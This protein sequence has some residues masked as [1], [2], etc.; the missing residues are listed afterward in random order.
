MAVN[1]KKLKANA[2]NASMN[3]KS[4]NDFTISTQPLKGKVDE[5]PRRSTAVNSMATFYNAEPLRSNALL[6]GNCGVFNR[7]DNPAKA[8]PA[9]PI[10]PQKANNG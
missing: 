4:E 10:S 1:A 5:R 3:D 9:K 8:I 6:Y 2:T 7:N